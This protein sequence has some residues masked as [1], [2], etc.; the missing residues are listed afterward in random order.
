MYFHALSGIRTW[1]VI[2]RKAQDLT[3]LRSRDLVVDNC[4][5]EEINGRKEG[6]ILRKKREGRK[7]ANRGAERKEGNY[8]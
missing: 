4:L 3:G 1:D 8:K 2:V 6:K 7:Q 5:R